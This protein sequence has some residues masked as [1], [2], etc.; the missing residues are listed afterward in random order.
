MNP[1]SMTGAIDTPTSAGQDISDSV[2][3]SFDDNRLL[4]LMFGEHDQHLTLIENRL[5]V[6]IMPRGNQVALRGEPVARDNAR[7]VLS[8][9]YQ[10]AAEGLEITPGDV[11]GAIR[12][13]H[14]PRQDS[15]SA[16]RVAG[17]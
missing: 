16:F 6:D 2:T 9:L 7:Q 1:R 3:L 4:A 15:A 14:L 5:G 12:M 8:D 11:D 17:E 10:R 13:A